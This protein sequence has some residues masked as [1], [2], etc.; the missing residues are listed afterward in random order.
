MTLIELWDGT[1]ETDGPVF[2]H[3]STP[4]SSLWMHCCLSDGTSDTGGPVN[5][6]HH[7]RAHGGT[8]ASNCKRSCKKKVRDQWRLT[9]CN[10]DISHAFKTAKIIAFDPK[11]CKSPDVSL[12]DE[13]CMC[14]SFV[15]NVICGQLELQ[16]L[17]VGWFSVG[18]FMVAARLVRAHLDFCTSWGQT[19]WFF[20]VLM[21]WLMSPLQC[22][23]NWE[24]VF[25][26]VCESQEAECERVQGSLSVVTANISISNHVHNRSLLTLYWI[27]ECR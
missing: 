18:W 2:S 16:P 8:A 26:T 10:S 7:G 12:Q 24:A 21:A 20:A 19:Q 9:Q 13:L 27:A 5:G 6:Q 22:V 1:S 17:K 15:A 14:W 11:M 3:C 25:D 23:I 4:W